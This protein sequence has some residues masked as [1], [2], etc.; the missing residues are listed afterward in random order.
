MKKIQFDTVNGTIEVTDFD[1]NIKFYGRFSEDDYATVSMILNH[2]ESSVI[3][4]MVISDI[5]F[6]KIDKEYGVTKLWNIN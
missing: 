5:L 4:G 1:T 2:H 3:G 6:D